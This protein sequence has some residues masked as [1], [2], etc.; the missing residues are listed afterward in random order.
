[1]PL[2]GRDFKWIL[3]ISVFIISECLFLME[4]ILKINPHFEIELFLV[5]RLYSQNCIPF[6]LIS[7]SSILHTFT[8]CKLVKAGTAGLYRG[9]FPL[10][11]QKDI[12]WRSMGMSPSAG[13]FLALSLHFIGAI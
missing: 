7:V 11:L 9:L 1:M 10:S 8:L 5:A 4:G 13:V 3:T 6:A 12:W 2:E